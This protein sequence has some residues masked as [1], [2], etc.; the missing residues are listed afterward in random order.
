MRITKRKNSESARS[1][2]SVPNWLVLRG[3]PVWLSKTLIPTPVLQDL[4]VYAQ[5]F[6]LLSH[7]RRHYVQAATP[8]Y[9]ASFPR[10]PQFRLERSCAAVVSPTPSLPTKAK[11]RCVSESGRGAR[12]ARVQSA[13][14]VLTI[15]KSYE[16]TGWDPRRQ[17]HSPR[18]GPDRPSRPALPLSMASLPFDAQTESVGGTRDWT[19]VQLR[20]TATRA[21]DNI[22]LTVGLRRRLQRQGVVFGR[23][24]VDE[25]QGV[26]VVA[27]WLP[28]R[29]RPTWLRLSIPGGRM[30]L[31]STSK[32]HRTS[33]GISS[34]GIWR[35]RK[36]RAIHG[37]LRSRAG[38]Q[39]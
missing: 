7:S 25:A 23:V 16:L 31:T 26:G 20:F 39:E 13:P 38:S 27:A 4:I 1:Q 22:A 28:P 24:T 12:D 15:G 33:A 3:G 10:Q 18:S 35:P 36:F 2:N 8:L 17:A 6:P 30:D 5:A 32:A 19:R 9:H 14:I 34:T 37:T 11:C 29:W 21:Q